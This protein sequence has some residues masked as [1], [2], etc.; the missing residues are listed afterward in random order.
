LKTD[1]KLIE[2]FR[3][4]FEKRRIACIPGQAFGEDRCIHFSFVVDQTTI[5][6]G[7]SR[8]LQI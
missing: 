1:A 6:E 2:T 4:S 7:L 8:L 3:Q 5:C